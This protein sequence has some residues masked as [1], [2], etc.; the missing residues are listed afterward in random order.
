MEE[1]TQEY[2]MG[3]EATPGRTVALLANRADGEILGEGTAGPAVYN[4]VGQE[5]SSRALWTAI[6]SAFKV[7]GFNTRDLMAADATLPQVAAVCIGMSGVERPKDEGQIRRILSEYNLFG[8]IQA[9]ND[10]AI[11]LETGCPDGYGLAVIAGDNGLAYAKNTDGRVARAGGWGY[12][13]GEEGSGY[14]LGWQAVRAVLRATDGRIAPT[15][16][17]KLIAREWSLP[18]NRPDMLAQRCYSLLAGLGSG[19]NK[20]QWEESTETYKRALAAFAPIVERAAASGDAAAVA[21]LDDSAGALAQSAQAVITRTGLETL[22]QGTLV[23]LAFYGSV[24]SS[25]P[26]ELRHRLQ[27][28]LPQCADPVLVT[29]PAR[30]ALRLALRLGEGLRTED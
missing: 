22:P 8:K 18:D 20:A 5:R 21:I 2:I 25:N 1:A 11:I 17:T 30:G 3:I 27:T 19:G 14:Y 23:P 4:V 10:A 13:L 12:L 26:G 24:L 7:A 15:S 16:L 6:L 29:H 28:H 9:T